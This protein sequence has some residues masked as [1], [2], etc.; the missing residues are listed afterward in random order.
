MSTD[1]DAA[2]SCVHFWG[3]NFIT[4]VLSTMYFFLSHSFWVIFILHLRSRWHYD[5]WVQ[6]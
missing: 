3:R 6:S 1:D 5:I 2:P 4:S